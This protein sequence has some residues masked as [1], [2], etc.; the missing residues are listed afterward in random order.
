M[1]ESKEPEQEPA[2]EKPAVDYRIPARLRDKLGEPATSGGGD[3]WEPQKRSPV[4][5]IVTVVIIV[6]AAAGGWWWWSNQQA[7]KRAEEARIAAEQARAAFVADSIAAAQAFAD[8]VALADSI[9]AFEALP[10]WRQRQIIAEKERAARQAA[11]GGTAAGSGAAGGGSAAGATAPAEPEAP[12]ESGPFAL[13]A[14]QYLF[15]D[16]ANRAAA[17]LKESTGM[18]A[19]VR[20]VG[21]GDDATYHVYLGRYSSRSAATA[22]AND[23]LGKGTVPQARVVK[24]PN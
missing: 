9:A 16:A 20:A 1:N 11:G 22:A 8:S 24:A 4:G 2:A 23:L 15:E 12:E 13:D 7:Q 19:V 5:A 10:R 14:G 18:E 3:E 21:S 6:A 17:T